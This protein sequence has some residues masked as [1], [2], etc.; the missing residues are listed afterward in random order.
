M[1]AK[2]NFLEALDSIDRNLKGTDEDNEIILNLLNMLIDANE[3]DIAIWG[4]VKELISHNNEKKEQQSLSIT[5]EDQDFYYD[6]NFIEPKFLVE[7]TRVYDNLPEHIKRFISFRIFLP[8]ECG[9]NQR[10]YE[11]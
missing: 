8:E 11:N 6:Y 2:I 9:P 4:K 10:A 7:R 1:E 5:F 3:E